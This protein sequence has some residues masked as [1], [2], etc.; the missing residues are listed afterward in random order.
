MAINEKKTELNAEYV[1]ENIK[2]IKELYGAE[3]FL[4]EKILKK[5]FQ[6]MIL[7]FYLIK[8]GWENGKI[9]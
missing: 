5:I 2:R 8:N 6:K 1:I 7:L 4:D 9:L 3:T